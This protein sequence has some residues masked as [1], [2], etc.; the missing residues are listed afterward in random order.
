MSN[1]D[2]EGEVLALIEKNE[3]EIERSDELNE[4]LYESSKLLL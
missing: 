3:R 2:E 4:A 1:E